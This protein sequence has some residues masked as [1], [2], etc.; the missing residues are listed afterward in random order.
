MPSPLL[1]LYKQ[2]KTTPFE[3]VINEYIKLEIKLH[4]AKEHKNEKHT[5]KIPNEYQHEQLKDVIMNHFLE[6]NPSF[7][8]IINDLITTKYSSAKR[9]K[10]ILPILAPHGID[11]FGGEPIQEFFILGE[12]G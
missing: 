5:V 6:I 11:I 7:H 4:Y 9:M 8:I 12:G 2:L 10:Q 1:L 3:E